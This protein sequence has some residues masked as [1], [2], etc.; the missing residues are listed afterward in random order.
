MLTIDNLWVH[1]GKTPA[2]QGV[3]LD[4]KQG[5]IVGLIGPNGAGKST[6]MLTAMGVRSPSAGDVTFDGK[7]IVGL[8]PEEIVRLGVSLVPER[9]RIFGPLTVEENLRIGA[10]PVKD[11]AATSAAM[12][13][14]LGRFPALETYLHKSAGLLSGGEQQQLAIGR[15]LLAQPRLLLFDEPSL[16]LGPVIIDLVFDRLEELRAEGMTILIVEQNA[17]Q[18]FDI[19][20]RVYV[21]RGGQI[22]ASGPS[23]EL[24][25][26][27]DF[28]A[29]LGA[30][31]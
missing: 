7:S 30:S 15:A 3:S 11:R 6:A 5:E 19:A 20:D 4:V 10:T 27:F 2:L 9:R 18:T 25:K 31:R 8:A 21:L 29:Y 16:G 1:Y 14:V 12:A 22:V 23:D 26:D 13:D 28:E 24:I 17:A